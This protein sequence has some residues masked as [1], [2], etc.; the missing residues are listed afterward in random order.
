MSGLTARLPFGLPMRWFQA[1][2]VKFGT[3]P[4]AD[5]DALPVRVHGTEFTRTTA[6]PVHVKGFDQP[7]VWVTLRR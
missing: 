5:F 6:A 4:Q 7:L 1:L 2:R 3:R